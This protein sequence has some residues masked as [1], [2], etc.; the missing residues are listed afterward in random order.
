MKK[1]IENSKGYSVDNKGNVFGPRKELKQELSNSGYYRVTIRYKDGAVVKK[2]VHRLV[3]ESFVPNPEGK[4]LV[5]HIDGNKV[6]N[7]CENLEWVDHKENARHASESGLL[8]YI[9]ES[10]YNNVNEEVLV[11]EICSLLEQGF[12]NKDVCE[13]LKVSKSLVSQVRNGTAWKHISSDYKL[14]KVRQKRVSVNTILWVCNRLEEG[15]TV[16]QIFEMSENIE[17]TKALVYDIKNRNSYKEISKP[18][19]F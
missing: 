13:R 10:H 17:V 2:S 11:R 18:F 6:N 19:K 3:A 8:S 9:G 5:N 14:T 7:Q 15:F 4:P 1:V 12:R 16:K